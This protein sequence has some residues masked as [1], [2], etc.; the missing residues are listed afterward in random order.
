MRKLLISQMISLDGFFSRPNGDLD[1]HMTDETFNDWAIEQLNS[2]DALVFGR[3]TYEG[4]RN[5]WTSDMARETDPD[6]TALMNAKPKIVFSKSLAEVTWANSRLIKTDLAA[7]IRDLKSEPGRDL[8][9][10]GSGQI[11]SALAS[12]GLIDEYRILTAPLI[13]GEGIPLFTDLT[14]QINLKLA[15]TRALPNGVILSTYLPA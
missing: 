11:T 6:V 5:W 13:L 12:A 3:K 8:V 14:A 9:I 15:T 10:F 1:W 2:V 4:M 7:A